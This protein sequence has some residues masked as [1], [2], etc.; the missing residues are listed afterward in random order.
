MQDV[1][2]LKYSFDESLSNVD[3]LLIRTK[4]DTSRPSTPNRGRKRNTRK[5]VKARSNR[6]WKSITS[7]ECC[8]SGC[9][10]GMQESDLT[11]LR[12][13]YDQLPTYNDQNHFLLNLL[14]I[15]C[16]LH[17]FRIVYRIIT[18]HTE[19][20]KVICREAFLKI[21]GISKK[22]IQVLLKKLQPYNSIPSR[23]QRG[24]HGKTRCIARELKEMV[25]NI[26]QQAPREDPIISTSVQ[27]RY[28]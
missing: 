10:Y 1:A 8:H 25:S 15:T 20:P 27:T 4:R 21:F 11:N 6:P 9:L 13:E 14:D 5:H 12:R 17:R 23:D 3:R 26:T 28:S 22:K 16:K 2:K 18:V 19:A 7:Y 24:R